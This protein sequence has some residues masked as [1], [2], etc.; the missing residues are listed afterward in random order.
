M[1]PRPRD[2]RRWR[3]VAGLVRTFHAVG[4]AEQL[5]SIRQTNVSAMTSLSAAVK[6][7][8]ACA[9]DRRRLYFGAPVWLVEPVVCSLSGRPGGWA[10]APGLS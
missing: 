3:A 2:S 9:S 8:L 10:E 1:Q 5:P 7:T 4:K 6:L